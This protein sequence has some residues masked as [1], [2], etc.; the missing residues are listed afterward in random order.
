MNPN[1]KGKGQSMESRQSKD[2]PLFFS[3]AENPLIVAVRS[4]RVRDEMYLGMRG[5]RAESAVLAIFRKH[6]YA[7]FP[8]GAGGYRGPDQFYP[9]V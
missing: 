7:F 6:A 5:M 9:P 4:A 2:H 8:R 1:H 3:P